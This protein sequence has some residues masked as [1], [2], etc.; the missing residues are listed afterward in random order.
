MIIDSQHE[1]PQVVLLTDSLSALEALAGGKLPQL[2]ARLQEAAK[3]R[4]VA[5]QWIP[6]H[7][8]IQG[9]EA[10]DELA[11]LGAREA[12]PDNSV[13]FMEKKSPCEGSNATKT[14]KRCHPIPRPS[15]AGYDH[16]TTNWS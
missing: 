8:G 16:E 1:C 9:N 15:A 14:H 13:S 4:R 3:Q 2:M 7:C 5:L 6:A 12:Q 11:K 10:A